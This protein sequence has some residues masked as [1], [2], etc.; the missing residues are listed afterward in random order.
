MYITSTVST[1]CTILYCFL[2]HASFYVCM[3][4]YPPLLRK[5]ETT[6][7]FCIEGMLWKVLSQYFTRKPE[8][9][10]VDHFPLSKNKNSL[11]G[12]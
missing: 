3:E 9:M 10:A 6:K 12:C 4:I 2:R 8:R 5:A 1:R 11:V 7:V